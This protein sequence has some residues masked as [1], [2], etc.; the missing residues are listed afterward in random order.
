MEVG[1][2]PNG[3]HSLTRLN[4]AFTEKAKFISVTGIKGL[5]KNEVPVYNDLSI[6]AASAFHEPAIYVYELAIPLKLL[7][8]P[9]NGTKAFSYHIKL[10][11][12]QE[13]AD[14]IRKQAPASIASNL[15]APPAPAPHYI[16]PTDFGGEYTL[17]KSK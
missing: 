14:Q 8:L 7:A 16:T 4:K 10:N 6:Q 2:N 13:F 15:E 5:T 1:G 3:D 9:E 17:A 11:P 12:S